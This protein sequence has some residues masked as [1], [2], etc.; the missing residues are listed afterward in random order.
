MVNALHSHLKAFLRRFNGV[1][2]RRL[3]R[4]LD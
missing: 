1:S 3:Q 2:T 4:Y